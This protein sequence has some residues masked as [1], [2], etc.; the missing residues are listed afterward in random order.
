VFQV[1]ESV[2]GIARAAAL[3]FLALPDR[4]GNGTLS[5]SAKAAERETG[6]QAQ[7]EEIQ[8]EEVV[9]W[10]CSDVASG[11]TQISP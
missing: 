11:G 8:K 9:Q 2:P 7:P 5:C 6:A 4:C 1:W 3:L 10:H